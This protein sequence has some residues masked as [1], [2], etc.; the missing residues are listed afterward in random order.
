M[1]SARLV[2]V[3]VLSLVLE[4]ALTGIENNSILKVF[5]SWLT[6]SSRTNGLSVST[7]D[8]QIFIILPWA[9]YFQFQTLSV[10]DLV[11]VESRRGTIETDLLTREGLVVS[12]SH[13][14]G[15]LRALIQASN[16]PFNCSAKPG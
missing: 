1:V 6:E 5:V 11:G 7:L 15:P 2:D 8:L 12:G 4:P 16:E 3:A 14:L 13:L 9:W 10:E